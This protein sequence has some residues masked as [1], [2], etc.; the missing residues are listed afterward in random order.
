MARTD[1]VALIDGGGGGSK[2]K[3]TLK[4]QPE[5]VGRVTEFDGDAFTIVFDKPT[6]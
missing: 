3:N 6:T 2:A 1:N 4:A 5:R